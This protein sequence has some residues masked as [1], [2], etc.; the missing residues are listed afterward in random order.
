MDDYY[1]KYLPYIHF[2]FKIYVDY[3]LLIIGFILKLLTITEE[4]NLIAFHLKGQE[5]VCK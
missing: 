3:K 5:D 2:A 4:L 1:I